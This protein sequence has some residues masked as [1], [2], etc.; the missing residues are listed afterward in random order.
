VFM[1]SSNAF[2]MQRTD[3]GYQGRVSSVYIVIAG[4]MMAVC[5]LAYGSLGTF[6]HPSVLMIAAG[7][8]FALL[9]VLIGLTSSLRAILRSTETRSESLAT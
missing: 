2:V 6:V 4:G 9:F 1:A 8:A 3:P 5:N 7:L